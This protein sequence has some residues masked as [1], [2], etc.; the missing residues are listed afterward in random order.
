M[1]ATA[2]LA[3]FYLGLGDRVG[4]VAAAASTRVLQARTGR[5]QLERVLTALLGTSAPGPG[6]VEPRLTVPPD[7]DPRA[8]V[9]VVSPLVGRAVFEQV[10]GLS[11]AGHAVVVVDTLPPD[12]LPADGDPW[13]APGDPAVAARAGHPGRPAPAARG[14]RRAVARQRQPRPGAARAHPCR[15][16]F[17]GPAVT[18]RIALA[19][20]GLAA[21]VLPLPRA[22][23]L[24]VLLVV[25]GVVGLGYSLL[26]P[27]STGPALVITT[28]VLAWLDSPDGPGRTARL[29]TLA[30]A[31][32]LVHSSAALAAV[33]PL[34][35]AVP[36]GLLLRW[37]GWTAAAT[38]VGGGAAAAASVLPATAPPV[39]ATVVAVLAVAAAG[40]TAGALAVRRR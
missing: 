13:T 10:A 4:L 30:L 20:A 1:R 17:R 24:G 14:A 27:G 36:A 33:V 37:A 26:R 28:A 40:A 32:A 29:A 15:R 35:A 2:A 9:L 23:P 38:A 21:I 12:A 31:V 19:V 22:T 34:R 25:T 18:P 7:L 16:S 6:G 8:L 5:G 11:R 39:P 3:A